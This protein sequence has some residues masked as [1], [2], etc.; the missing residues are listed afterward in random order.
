MLQGVKILVAED[1]KLNQKILNFILLKQRAEVTIACNGHE[2][3]DFLSE[4]NFDIILMDLQMPGMDGYATAK[5]IRTNLK[6]QVPII[7]LT[8]DMAAENSAE[9]HETGMNACISKPVQSNS[10][11]RLISGFVDQKVVAK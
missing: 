9:Y 8:A 10:L 3:I 7:A 11:C 4:Y 1:D 2:V 6:N 5:F